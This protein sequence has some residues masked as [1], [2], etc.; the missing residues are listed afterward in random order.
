MF[1]VSY[2]LFLLFEVFTILILNNFVDLYIVY[3][4]KKSNYLYFRSNF[5]ADRFMDME[6]RYSWEDRRRFNEEV[7]YYEWCRMGPRNMGIGPPPLFGPPSMIGAR[8]PP[9]HLVCY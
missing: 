4:L 8:P 3:P 9:P 5:W 1:F 6:D 2:G 7:D